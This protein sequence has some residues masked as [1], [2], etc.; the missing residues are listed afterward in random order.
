MSPARY[1]SHEQ[2]LGLT[3]WFLSGGKEK[4][5]KQI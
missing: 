2:K 3:V 4:G 5:R 1:T